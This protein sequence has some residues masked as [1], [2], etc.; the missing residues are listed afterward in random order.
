MTYKNYRI[1]KKEIQ[2]NYIRFELNGNI[3]FSNGSYN[4]I[5]C[6]NEY[7]FKNYR[8]GDE[9]EV[10][11]NNAK[12]MS[13]QNYHQE[14][15]R[16][17]SGSY[18]GG[19][20]GLQLDNHDLPR[21]EEEE[22]QKQ[23]LLVQKQKT[24]HQVKLAL[25]SFYNVLEPLEEFIDKAGYYP[26]FRSKRQLYRRV[27]QDSEGTLENDKNLLLSDLYIFSGAVEG[28]AGFIMEVLKEDFYR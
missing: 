20:Y 17:T 7:P 25:D 8:V 2:P 27:I 22:E 12:H 6:V 3:G 24:L 10:N 21:D 13:S 28:E 4:F 16:Q 23:Q 18:S 26:N 11:L 19:Y 1:K 14:I 5:F 15:I 9:I